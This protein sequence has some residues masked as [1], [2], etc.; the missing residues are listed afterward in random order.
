MEG[1]P[2]RVVWSQGCYTKNVNLGIFL[3]IWKGKYI[4]IC[5]YLFY[6]HL[7]YFLAIWYI[8][9]PFGNFV[10]IWNIFPRFGPL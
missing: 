5:M 9:W 6:G 1:R 7:V 3:G 2:G 8:S 4:G 10:I